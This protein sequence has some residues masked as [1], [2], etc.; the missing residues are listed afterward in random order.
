MV[1]TQFGAYSGDSTT[2][3]QATVVTHYNNRN[4]IW[5]KKAARK[6]GKIENERRESFAARKEGKI[7]KREREREGGGEAP[8]LPQ[9]QPKVYKF[10]KKA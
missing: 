8:P 3:L 7:E 10:R 2:P 1:G 9:Q 6:E 5:K 4:Q